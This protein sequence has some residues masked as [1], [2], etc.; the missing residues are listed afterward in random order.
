[1]DVEKKCARSKENRF[2]AYLWEQRVNMNVFISVY[3]IFFLTLHSGFAHKTKK[4]FFSGNLTKLSKNSLKVTTSHAY[5]C[6]LT[7]SFSFKVK[8][9]LL[10]CRIFVFFNNSIKRFLFP[11]GELS[12][13][14]PRIKDKKGSD[15]YVHGKIHVLLQ[16]QI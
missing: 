9:S 4:L 8:F 1:M 15:Y 7:A 2:V 10:L 5:I 11:I 3:M 14:G 16:L 12:E 6:N 13:E